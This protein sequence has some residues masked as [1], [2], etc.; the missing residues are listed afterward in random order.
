MLILNLLWT[1]LVGGKRVSCF[2]RVPQSSGC[3]LIFIE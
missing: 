1:T 2:K 3:R